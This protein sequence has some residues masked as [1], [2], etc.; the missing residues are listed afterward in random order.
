[1]CPTS[2]VPLYRRAGGQKRTAIGHNR[3]AIKQSIYKSFKQKIKMT[4]T[5]FY[6][7]AAI[8]FA[9]NAKML[10]ESLTISQWLD[11]IANLAEALTL[12]VEETAA[13]DPENSLQ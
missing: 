13:F 9:S 3:G 6:H 12:R 5:E 2:Y 8:A 1:M 10:P 7:K 4:R 11:N